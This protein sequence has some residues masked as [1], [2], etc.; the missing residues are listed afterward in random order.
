MSR[1]SAQS[2][3]RFDGLAG[4]L[5]AACCVVAVLGFAAALPAFSHAQHPLGLLGARGVPGAVF[6]NLLG[7]VLPGLLAAWT[8]VR[9]RGRL[10]DGIGRLAPLGAWMLVISALAFAAQG[11]LTLDPHDLDGAVSQRHATAWLL[12]WLAFAPGA[13]LLGMGVLREHAWRHVAVV[14]LVAGALAVVLNVLPP[15][16][17]VGPLA[18][19]LLLL[20]WLASV[21]VASRSR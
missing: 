12:W 19:R 3:S 10:P 15:A 2:P 16:V 18:Q 8:F 5:A 14:F 4:W 17:L 9:L 11:L 13:L 1:P 7:F 6:F 21:V 20:V